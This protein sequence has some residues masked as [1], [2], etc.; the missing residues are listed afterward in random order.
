MDRFLPEAREVHA[1]GA[2]SPSSCCGKRPAAHRLRKLLAK[3]RDSRINP[4][5]I[6]SQAKICRNLSEAS[7]LPH[8]M[9]ALRMTWIGGVV[10]RAAIAPIPACRPLI[11]RLRSHIAPLHPSELL[12]D[13]DYCM[14]DR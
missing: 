7:L 10:L 13:S 9:E 14:T 3:P 4:I 6:H 12:I 11:T 2:C 5:Y 8:V 1:C